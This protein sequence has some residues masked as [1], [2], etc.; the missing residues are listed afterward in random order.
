[1]TTECLSPLDAI[2]ADKVDQVN[3][4]TSRS[5]SLIFSNSAQARRN[6][7]RLDKLTAAVMLKWEDEYRRGE[8]VN[9]T[10]EQIKERWFNML[11]P[12]VSEFVKDK[13]LMPLE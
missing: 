3:R 6:R 4:R 5:I 11:Q 9:F 2:V 13:M 12:V 8:Y 7:R 1:M 10:E